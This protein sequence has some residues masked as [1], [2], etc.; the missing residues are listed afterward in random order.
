VVLL[1]HELLIDLGTVSCGRLEGVG[2]IRRPV[3]KILAAFLLQSLRREPSVRS[4]RVRRIPMLEQLMQAQ[5]TL[6]RE[7]RVADLAV[8]RC[9]VVRYAQPALGGFHGFQFL[10][11]RWLVICPGTR[12]SHCRVGCVP[13]GEFGGGTLPGGLIRFVPPSC[14]TGAR[15]LTDC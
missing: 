11:F 3:R 2:V 12:G 10:P 5:R 8:V 14:E 13:P 15:H 4:V 9:L 6:V 7:A 1:R